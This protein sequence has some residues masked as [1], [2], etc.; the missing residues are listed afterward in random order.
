TSTSDL[1]AAVHLRTD[2]NPLFMV[3]LADEL[4]AVGLLVEDGGGWCLRGPLGDVA[5]A[6]PESLRALIDKQIGRLEPGAQRVLEVAGVLGDQFTAE[7][8]AAGLG[9]DPSVV[10][11]HCDALSRQGQLVVPG[12]LAMLPD[13]TPLAQYAFTHNLYPQVL[14]AR[15]PAAR[16]VR[17]HLRIGDWLERAYAA[18]PA[19]VSTQL[20]WHFEEGHDHR[21]AIRH[22]ISTA[23]STAGRFA[24]RDAIRVL[25]RALAL[26]ATLDAG[27][28][29]SVE[30]EILE[31]IGDAQYWLGTIDEC[32]RSYRA[33]AT[34]AA[35]AGLVPAQGRALR[36]LF[37]PLG[38]IDPD[39]SIAAVE[40]AAQLSAGCDDPLLHACTELLAGS[41]RLWYDRWRQEDWAR[42][43]SARERV[44][45]LSAAGLPQYYR[46]I[47]AHLEVLQGN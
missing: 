30:I 33:E 38:L 9:D 23:E 15:V 14:G 6:V 1:A 29:P 28:R 32:A 10:E 47:Y 4:V 19:A 24:Y 40:Q 43:A 20:A 39:Q 31:R 16:R 22:L 5:H 2:G 11:A 26:A 27:V 21:R 17:L 44:H 46:M 35:E 41:M 12:P 3:R 18:A 8:I 7:A 37:R 34:R 25:Q 36:C 42:C 13:G 45:S